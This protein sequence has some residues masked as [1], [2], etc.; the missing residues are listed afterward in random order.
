MIRRVIVA[1]GSVLLV[2]DVAV[3]S[4][5]PALVSVTPETGQRGQKLTLTITGQETHFVQDATRVG[6]T[7]GIKVDSISVAS[8]TSLQARI[9]I[10][11]NARL[12]PHTVTVSTHEK[13]A[14]KELVKLPNAFAV[15]P[16]DAFTTSL[17][18]ARLV[19]GERTAGLLTVAIQDP[20]PNKDMQVLLASS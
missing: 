20:D 17:E 7:A 18:P 5:A 6:F 4:A 3:L 10:S 9:V 2:A 14:K 16:G 19:I 12:G 15:L 1:L 13:K 8:A 11:K